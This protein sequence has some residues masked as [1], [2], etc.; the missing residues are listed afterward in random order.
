MARKTAPRQPT[1]PADDS[2]SRDLETFRVLPGGEAL[3]T[4]QGVKIADTH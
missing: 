1:T 2:K 4:N 3:R